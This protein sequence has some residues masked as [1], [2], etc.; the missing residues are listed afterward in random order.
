MNEHTKRLLN[1]IYE[2]LDLYE[3]GKIDEE[4][5]V[6]NIEGNCTAIEEHTIADRVDK[7]ILAVEYSEY[8]VPK[9]REFVIREIHALKESVS[10]M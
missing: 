7:F 5:L 9:R 4:N 3:Q 1:R 8:G 6:H 2:S 10:N